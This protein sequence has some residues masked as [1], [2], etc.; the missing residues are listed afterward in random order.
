M[1]QTSSSTGS[2]SNQ[3]HAHSS[4]SSGRQK[5]ISLT[6]VRRDASVELDDETSDSIYSESGSD[7]D[8]DEEQNATTSRKRARSSSSTSIEQT[9]THPTKYTKLKPETRQIEATVIENKWRNTTSAAQAKVKTVLSLVERP[10]IN[11]N[12]EPER[13]KEAQASLAA[14]SRIM[15]TRLPHVPFPPETKEWHFDYEAILRSNRDLERQVAAAKHSGMLAQAEIVK[16]QRL[17]EAAE[18]EL[19]DLE[20]N[21]RAEQRARIQRE[22][23]TP[24]IWATPEEP[25]SDDASHIGLQKSTTRPVNSIDSQEETSPFVKELQNH[26]EG[27]EDNIAQVIKI[28]DSVDRTSNILSLVTRS[29]DV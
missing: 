7:S 21:A 10:V 16:E 4:S 18:A 17:L 8:D 28:S 23:G 25:K 26:L 24:Q 1:V 22:R 20:K 9:S 12:R 2:G 11:A 5:R 14:L 29:I 3:A 19:E 13:R 6:K 27:I 15:E